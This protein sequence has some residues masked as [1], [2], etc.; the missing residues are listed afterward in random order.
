[1]FGKSSVK[2][3]PDKRSVVWETRDRHSGVQH[4][5]LAVVQWCVSQL[6][7]FGLPKT[8]AAPTS[9]WFDWVSIKEQMIQL[10]W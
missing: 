5:V 9:T 10:R 6:S 4:G 7:V 8:T 2:P 1:M 3:I